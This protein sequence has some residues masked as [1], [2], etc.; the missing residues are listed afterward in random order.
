MPK[1][2]R[3]TRKKKSEET[4]EET[5]SEI[6][7]QQHITSTPLTREELLKK[8]KRKKLE[9][10]WTRIGQSVRDAEMDRIRDR[11][12]EKITGKERMILKDK[13]AMLED[14]DEREVNNSGFG[15]FVDFTDK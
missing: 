1:R 6:S 2:K 13:L 5:K 4:F 3:K 11:L 12:E 9:M 8:M 14:I 10:Y 7:S 15:E